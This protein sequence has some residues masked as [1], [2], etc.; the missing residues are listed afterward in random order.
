MSIWLRWGRLELTY[1]QRE[2][3]CLGAVEG[4]DIGLNKA[5]IGDPF[6]KSWYMVFNYYRMAIGLA[7]PLA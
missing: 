7:K 6:M 4:Q 5:N 3:M 1:Y 2:G